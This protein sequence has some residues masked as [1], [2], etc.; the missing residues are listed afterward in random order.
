MCSAASPAAGGG[1][2]KV[3]VVPKP[4]APHTVSRVQ[5]EKRRRE[6]VATNYA[7]YPVVS[8]SGEA[9]GS[10][11]LASAVFEMP[12]RKD[13][14]QR[15][16]LWQQARKRPDAI[17][18]KR[19]GEVSGG[20]RKPWHQKGSGRARHGSIRSPLWRGGGKAHGRRA[21]SWAF[22]MPKKVRRLAL[23]TAISARMQEGRLVIVE[24]LDIE[25]HKTSLL[26]GVLDRNGWDSALVISEA[27]PD[28][29]KLA[30]SNIATVDVLPAL[31]ANV[32][33]ILKRRQ[34]VI[35]R[36][37]VDYLHKFLLRL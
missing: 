4:A 23:R 16:V 22:D 34:L 33:S 9:K 29:F 6:K 8:L 21:K 28:N 20:G 31:G 30:C 37:G 2:R 26:Q 25:D 15:V 19:R 35:S 13:L 7:E 12:L 17:P 1:E 3:V 18:V 10:I 11:E 24:D 5:E 36:S 27:V 32:Y 14:L